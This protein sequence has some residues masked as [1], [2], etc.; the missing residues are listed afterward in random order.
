M[1]KISPPNTGS[2][3]IRCDKYPQ[4]PC[5]DGYYT[6]ITN[7]HFHSDWECGKDCE[8]GDVVDDSCNCVC[9]VRPPFCPKVVSGRQIPAIMDGNNMNIDAEGFTLILSGKD[10]FIAVLSV[11][12]VIL[13][14]W[15]MINVKNS[16]YK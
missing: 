9:Y 6:D 13:M 2:I 5:N 3:P 15:W 16:N 11:T 12:A 7:G 14:I 10:I 1:G 4:G 8:G